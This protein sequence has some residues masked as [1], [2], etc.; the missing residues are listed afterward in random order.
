MPNPERAPSIVAG[1]SSTATAS[2]RSHPATGSS[3]PQGRSEPRF[4][5]GIDE[6]VEAVVVASRA[7]VSRSPVRFQKVYVLSIKDV[8]DFITSQSRS[9]G[10]ST[11]R[12]AA[13][14]LLP[15]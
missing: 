1:D 10:S 15:P 7:S 14:T 5:A 4:A 8:V 3:A 2:G 12:R 9:L 11:V 6:W 13:T